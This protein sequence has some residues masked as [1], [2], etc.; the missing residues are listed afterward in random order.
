MG[1]TIQSLNPG[2]DKRS[3]VLKHVVDQLGAHPVSRSMDTVS[4]PWERSGW[5]MKF[6]TD[7]HLMLRLRLSGAILLCPS[8]SPY[9][10]DMDKFTFMF[11]ILLV[12]L[13]LLLL[14]LIWI[15]T[16]PAGSG[17]ECRVEG[18]KCNT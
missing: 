2:R 14:L 6:T 4:P 12:M 10:M 11:Y 15:V 18:K 3:S 1:W 17:T 13:T 5:G 8:I 16:R 7:A 9:G